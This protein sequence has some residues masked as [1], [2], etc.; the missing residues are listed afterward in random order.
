MKDYE[1][2]TK[3]VFERIEEQ[4]QEQKKKNAKL[5]IAGMTSIIAVP[6][7]ALV[8]GGILFI[9]SRT[10]IEKAQEGEK[11]AAAQDGSSNAIGIPD[12]DS[13]IGIGV[14]NDNSQ[15]VSR[16]A[17]TQK[18]MTDSS[19][20][21]TQI[22]ADSSAPEKSGGNY[23][24]VNIAAIPKNNRKKIV[25]EKITEEEARDYFTKNA[26]SLQSSLI[27]SGVEIAEIR[28]ETAEYD[29]TDP[30]LCAKG[31]LLFK[32][33]YCH[34]SYDG[35]VDESQPGLTIKQNIMDFQV[36]NAGN[37]VAIVTLVKENGLIYSTPAF[38]APWFRD[39]NNFTQ[40]Y[41]GKKLLYIYAGAMEY[42]ITPDN[43]VVNAQSLTDNNLSQNI[44]KD[45][46][47]ESM[48]DPYSWFY[49]EQCTMKV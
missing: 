30:V 11:A 8:I 13:S 39:F 17:I 25:G 40:K 14:L 16:P 42:V 44:V 48:K 4:E 38:G 41:Q 36:F 26:A 33:G 32:K 28:Y 2:M 45:S 34:I 12:S 7:L 27:A 1:Q 3:A 6:M 22:T 21:S 37:L 23:G 5:R 20:A 9:S 29:F 46:G 43:N 18:V 35:N 10:G 49:D 24:T 31:S 15:K 19:T 47:L